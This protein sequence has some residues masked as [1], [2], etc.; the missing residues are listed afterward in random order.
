[1]TIKVMNKDEAK[2][3]L[4]TKK[5]IIIRMGDTYPFSKLKGEYLDILELYFSDVE[6]KTNQYAIKKEDGEKVIN[7]VKKN[8]EKEVEEIIVH[9]QYGKGRSPAIAASLAHNMFNLPFDTTKYPNINNLVYS[10]IEKEIYSKNNP[11]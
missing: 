1:M 10:T 5:T 2:E 3:Y 7:F 11:F 6:D 8:I 9:C 4:P